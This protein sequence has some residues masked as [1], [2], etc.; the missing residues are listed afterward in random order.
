MTLIP[1]CACPGAD[2]TASETSHGPAG[3]GF[4]TGT[5]TTVAPPNSTGTSSDAEGSTSWM[6]EL[7]DGCGDGVIEAGVACYRLVPMV[8]ERPDSAAAIDVDGDGRDEVIARFTT[9]GAMD[10]DLRRFALQGDGFA[11]LQRFE[12]TFLAP[13]NFRDFDMD[14]DERA[15]LISFPHLS[16][17]GEFR[18][19]STKGGT[20][21]PGKAEMLPV[22]DFLG[23]DHSPI[24]IE[25]RGG[26][27]PELVA[28]RSL[29]GPSP[30]DVELFAY[31]GDAWVG[32]GAVGRLDAG[33]G[34]LTGSVRAD[35]DEDGVD[36]LVI[37]D[38]GQAC[39]PYPLEYEPAWFRFVVL[40]ADPAAGTLHQ[41]NDVAIGAWPAGVVWS[42]DF[43]GDG[44]ADVLFD[45]GY[46][47]NGFKAGLA[48]VHHGRGD[49][50]FNPPVVVDPGGWGG[51]RP[52][53]I[54]NF[55]GIHDHG[56]LL[57]S[58]PGLLA[59][60]QDAT[61]P[62]TETPVAVAA[63]R[64]TAGDFNGDGLDDLVLVRPGVDH[65]ADVLLSFP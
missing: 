35:F 56:A 61:E 24:P 58:E 37:F 14:G 26:G 22:G 18:W 7:P 25:V 20:L 55:L 63:L 40:L 29:G 36:D 52:W 32:L 62:S 5:G 41:A 9:G 13:S 27:R 47:Q 46:D 42:R 17:D 38:D 1:G 21:A 3:S 2:A 33:C 65:G 59:T 30:R 31:E 6:Y 10:V 8:D 64:L 60:R 4:G 34:L 23:F 44:H 28:M 54:G 49:G 15:D 39:D 51:R 19:Y 16:F 50:T 11:E 45:L 12:H 57:R 43:D 53:E 48:V